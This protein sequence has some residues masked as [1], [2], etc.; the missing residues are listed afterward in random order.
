ME[1]LKQLFDE[2][3]ITGRAALEL[4]RELLRL[5]NLASS[6]PDGPR[7]GIGGNP[8]ITRGNEAVSFAAAAARAAES[9]LP[10][11]ETDEIRQQEGCLFHISTAAVWYYFTLAPRRPPICFRATSPIAQS[12]PQQLPVVVFG[13]NSL[14]GLRFVRKRSGNLC[15]LQTEIWP[16]AAL[17]TCFQQTSEML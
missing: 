11:G 17:V 1:I 6:R 7:A 9:T 4:R 13:P 10:R 8:V 14:L 12:L 5:T 16:A 3:G 2:L 15:E